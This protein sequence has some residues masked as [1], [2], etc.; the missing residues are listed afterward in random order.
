MAIQ[1]TREVDKSIKGKLFWKQCVEVKAFRKDKLVC[2]DALKF[3]ELARKTYLSFPEQFKEGKIP[4]S[5]KM[6]LDGK[7][8]PMVAQKHTP[9][10]RINLNTKRLI[11]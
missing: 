4:L 1:V 3:N 6:E 9:F 8:I 10:L 5:I 2:S 7:K 11:L